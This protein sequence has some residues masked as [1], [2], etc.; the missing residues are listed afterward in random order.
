MNRLNTTS[1]SLPPIP[2]KR[3]KVGLI[4]KYIPTVDKKTGRTKKMPVFYSYIKDVIY[5]IDGWAD[6]KRFLPEDFDLV[7][8]RLK[9]NRTI[10]GWINGLSWH[11]SRLKTNDEVLFWKRKEEEL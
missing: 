3:I 2:A 10:P 9:R 6:A 11:G 7:Y 8:L 1:S 5:D 4:K